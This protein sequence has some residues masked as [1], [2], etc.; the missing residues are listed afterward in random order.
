MYIK[1]DNQT[2]LKCLKNDF[3]VIPFTVFFIKEVEVVLYANFTFS[4]EI[5][6]LAYINLVAF[7]LLYKICM[8]LI[9]KL[10][11]ILYPLSDND[12]K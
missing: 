10:S 6:L 12:I 9:R 4:N 11:L 3:T 7:L 5:I 8:I 2:F 1:T